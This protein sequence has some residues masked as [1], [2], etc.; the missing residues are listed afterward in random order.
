MGDVS[1]SEMSV[2]LP[3]TMAHPSAMYV[4][5]CQETIEDQACSDGPDPDGYCWQES[6]AQEYGMNREEYTTKFCTTDTGYLEYFQT[7]CQKMCGLCSE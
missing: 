1:W 7:N 4:D 2:T 3:T 5:I 6:W